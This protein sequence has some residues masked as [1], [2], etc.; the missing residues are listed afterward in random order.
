M[1]PR[2]GL[3]FSRNISLIRPTQKLLFTIPAI[4]YFFVVI[5]FQKISSI[6]CFNG[7]VFDKY[8]FVILSRIKLTEEVEQFQISRDRLSSSWA[9]DK[10]EFYFGPTKE[11]QN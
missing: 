11:K 9:R 6:F 4:L 10:T 5:T 8:L 3:K 7:R 1:R 2:L